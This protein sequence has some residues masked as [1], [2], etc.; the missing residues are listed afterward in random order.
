MFFV[1]DPPRR[2]DWEGG[3]IDLAGG[4]VSGVPASSVL[5][6]DSSVFNRTNRDRRIWLAAITVGP[7]ALPGGLAFVWVC[8]LHLRGIIPLPFRWLLW[9]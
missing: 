6:Y 4:A 9:C 7:M 8:P 2:V 3:L 5:H 1:P